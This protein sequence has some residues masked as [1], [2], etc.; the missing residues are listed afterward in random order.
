MAAGDRGRGSRGSECGGETGSI[1]GIGA[2]VQGAPSCNGWTFW[3]YED[4]KGIAPVDKLRQTYLL[5]TEI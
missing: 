2:K 1:H 5:A 4:E 3:H